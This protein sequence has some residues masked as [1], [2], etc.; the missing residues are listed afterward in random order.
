MAKLLRLRRGTDTQHTT[1]TGAEGEVTVNTTNDSLHVH[2]GAT[3][4]GR[5]VMRADKNNM[6][7]SG[8]TAGTYGSSSAIPSITVDAKGLVTSATTSAIDSTSITNGTSNVSV[9]ASGDITVTRSGTVVGTFSSG[10]LDVPNS[11]TA[12]KIVV[13]DDGA[14]SP[15]M[16]VKSDDN[17]TTGFVVK[18]DT[19]STNEEIGFKINQGNDG[20][21]AVMNVGNS[22]YR[23]INFQTLNGSGGVKNA[24]V[25]NPEA[26]VDLYYNN[27][28]KLQTQSGGINVT[29]R[30][31]CDGLTCDG[32]ATIS[33]GTGLL[34]LRD[35]D[36]TGVGV[37][38]YIQGEDSGAN[39]RWQI[40]QTTSGNEQL[41]IINV[42]NS[43]IAFYTNNT[44]RALIT[45]GGH[46][47]PTVTNTYDLGG[48]SNQWRDGY[49]DGTVHCDGLTVDGNGTINGVGT[50]QSSTGVLILRDNDNNDADTAQ[51]YIE[52]RTADGTARYRLGDLTST[53][54]LYISNMTSNS[55]MFQT[56]NTT[57]C[58]VNSQGHFL[59]DSNNTYDLGTSSY[60]WRNV[61]TNDL[62]LSNEGGANDV[63]G[64]WGSWTIQEGEDDLFLLNRRNGKKYKFNLS[65]VN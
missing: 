20:T 39:T 14:S 10:G 59:P 28:V 11:I 58:S 31:T 7:N 34:R 18:N 1:F 41:R 9:A 6:P 16:V 19:Y 56:N 30:V 4:G 29:G 54:H 40:G 35:S 22:Q 26:S 48:S 63:D 37:T 64:T 8:V 12:N 42:A 38:N 17:A 27:S 53:G 23:G 24:I 2:D 51:N 60:R 25:V 44:Q 36:T 65:E 5:E 43:D 61:Y 32:D 46:F 57:R 52:A 21:V 50:I 45:N 3:A 55:V 15:T 33:A 47:Q 49:F 62:N 13:D